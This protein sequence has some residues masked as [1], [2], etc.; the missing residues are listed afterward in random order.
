MMDTCGKCVICQFHFKRMS[1]GDVA[2]QV[3]N[4]SKSIESFEYSASLNV[5]EA[6]SRLLKAKFWSLSYKNVNDIRQ[7]VEELSIQSLTQPSSGGI[8]SIEYTDV[9]PVTSALLNRYHPNVAGEVIHLNN[10][11]WSRSKTI[12]KSKIIVA[13]LSSDFGVHPISS[14]IRGLV[15]FMD[16]DMFQVTCVFTYQ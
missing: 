8:S 5:S 16:R 4:I 13:L 10:T 1:R 12:K 3:W 15:Q 11:H 9:G 14:L 7:Q 2:L 6:L